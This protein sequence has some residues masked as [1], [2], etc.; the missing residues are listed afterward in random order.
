MDTHPD[1][2]D[3]VAEMTRQHAAR[4]RDFGFH[5]AAAEV[6]AVLEPPELEPASA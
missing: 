4:L 2:D 6:D 3:A 1:F 5:R